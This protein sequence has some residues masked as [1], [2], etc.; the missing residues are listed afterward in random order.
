MKPELDVGQTL[1]RIF[2]VYG[3]QAG[4]L[5]P[6]A[7]AVFLVE[8][9]VTAL[10]VNASAALVLVAVLVSMIL[11]TLYAGMVVE[12][13]HDV[14]DGRRDHTVGELFRS[15]TGV[16]ATLILV[17]ILVGIMAAI[18][19]VLLIVPGLIV[20]TIFAVAAPA[21]VIERKGVFEALGRSRELVRGNG[22]RV[23][24]VILIVFLLTFVVSALIGGIA[25]SAG[26]GGRIIGEFVVSTLTAPISA[27]AAA[28]LFFELRRLKEG[29]PQ[30]SAS[31]SAGVPGD[32]AAPAGSEP[33]TPGGI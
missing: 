32:P 10:L 20:L 16:V 22:M 2:G 27:L 23:F 5:I 6:V 28:V 12:L 25:G 21:V 8:A 26:T 3:D 14:Q 19:F 4:V 15:V 1:S 7:A 30:E 31:A 17:G 18:G 13:V 33:P 11:S 29:Q 24:G 9:V